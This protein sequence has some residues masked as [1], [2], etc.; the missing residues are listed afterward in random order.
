[1]ST[2]EIFRSQRVVTEAGVRPAA[3]YVK[4]GRIARVTAWADVPEG[5]ALVDLG[6]V[7]LMPGVV[8]THVHI[9]EPGRTEWE[10]F[11]SA[12]RAAAAGGITTVVDMPLNSIPPATSARGVAVKSSLTEG[13]VFVDVGLW[14]GA[15]PE[16][17]S[18][19]AKGL[20][21]VLA[22]GALGFKCFLVPSGVEEFPYVQ[23]DDVRAALAQLRDAGCGLMVHA[24]LPGPIDRAAAELRG[25]VP[26][27]DPRAYRTYVRSRPREAEDRAIELLLELCR[28]FRVPIHVV[29]LSSSGALGALAKARDE[30][31]PLTAETAPHYLHFTAE[32]VPDGATW[33]KCAPPIREK[34]NQERLWAALDDGLITMVV[35]DHSPCTPDL[36]RMDTGDFDAAW[37]G[38]AGLQFSLP[39]VWTEASARGY[40]LDRLAQWMCAAPARHAGLQAKKGGIAAGLDA[41]LVAFD[42][43]ASFTVDP[44]KVHHRNK[45]TPYAGETLRGV[46]RGTWLRGER[47]YDGEGFA[48]GARGRWVRR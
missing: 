45:V 30:G 31:L 12:T 41:D 35:S 5:A 44:A 28:E 37:G 34:E 6:D 15:V 1:M 24:E 16:N 29:H 20:G 40:G 43:E 38:I 8:D 25:E 18:G 22:E 32:Q 39:A 26:P 14:G 46:V 48:E 7:A 42:S 21:K 17:T 19:D 2:D 47:V 9:N 36:K 11:E 33:F 10:G 4:D 27:P 3:V 23:R 13:R